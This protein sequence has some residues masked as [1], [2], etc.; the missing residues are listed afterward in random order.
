MRIFRCGS[1]GKSE[2]KVPIAASCT[3]GSLVAILHHHE[4][5]SDIGCP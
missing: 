2:P 4:T 3:D 5:L 1:E